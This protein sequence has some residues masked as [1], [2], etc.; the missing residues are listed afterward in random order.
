MLTVEVVCHRV[1][2]ALAFRMWLKDLE[3]SAR[4]KPVSIVWRDKCEGWAPNHITYIFENGQNWSTTS[5][6]NLF[7]KGFLENLYLR[8]SCYKCKHAR[9][10]RIADITLADFWGYDGSMRK[11]NVNK[12]LSI[13]IATTN[14]GNK[15]LK[16]VSKDLRQE[17]VEEEYVKRLSRHVW[18]HPAVNIYL[19]LFFRNLG[20]WGFTYTS[21]RY[22]NPNIFLRIL[23][24][25]YRILNYNDD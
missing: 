7:Q 3:K 25:I 13:V 12:G 1:P 9:L 22:L 2:S 5:Q 14:K 19:S 15:M 4:S 23:R 21:Q 17:R 10:P 24:K 6:N 8:P 16:V 11:D 20:R 18:K